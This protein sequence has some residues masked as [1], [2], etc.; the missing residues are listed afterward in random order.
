MTIMLKV[1]S[2]MILNF[3]TVH[4]FK[5]TFLFFCRQSDLMSFSALPEHEQQML[6]HRCS[7]PEVQGDATVCLHHKKYYLDVFCSLQRACCNPFSLHVTPRRKSLRTVT[8]LDANNF[9]HSG[10]KAGMK[11]CPQCRRHQF[12]LNVPQ[13][14]D[15]PDDKTFVEPTD[16]RECLDDSF[17]AIGLSPC[18]ISRV[19]NRD[20]VSYIQ[21]KVKQVQDK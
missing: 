2:Y 1:T 3:K 16:V 14:M 9:N 6:K 7:L 15:I 18:K 21:R 11:L 12:S 20:S 17:T 13:S 8:L 19:S 10:I 5:I 4:G